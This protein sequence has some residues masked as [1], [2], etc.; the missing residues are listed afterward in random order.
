[1]PAA[2]RAAVV[3]LHSSASSGR[4]WAALAQALQ[5]HYRVHLVDLHGHGARPAWRG[6]ASQA[7]ADDAELVA[8][9][10][11]DGGAHL[12]GHSYGGAV[13]LKAASLH[14]RAVHSLV[15]FEPVLFRWMLEDDPYHPASQDVLSII[16]TIRNRL[17]CDEAPVAA[18]AFVTFWSGQAAWTALPVG[19]RDAIAARMPTVL[20]HFDALMREPLGRAQ[21]AGLDMPMLFASG[22][23]TVAATRRL[24]LLL[25]ATVPHASHVTLP[26]MGHMGP[27]THALAFIRQVVWF[28]RTLATAQRAAPAAWHM[29]AA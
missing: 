18:E 1:M 7:L 17:D 10:L 29:A 23:S 25:R 24:A 20:A 16:A 5:P 6:G 13:A 14:P 9:L 26:G 3:L 28:L 11:A 12:V 4:Q 27:V 22:A 15:A 21:L 2:E 19:A 8:P